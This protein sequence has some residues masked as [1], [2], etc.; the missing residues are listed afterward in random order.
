M[1]HFVRGPPIRHYA[2]A[3]LTTLGCAPQLHFDYTGH[4][5]DKARYSQGRGRAI[6][7]A[8]PFVRFP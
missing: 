5:P 2:Q 4:P 7:T 1:R 6:Y 3:C 8:P